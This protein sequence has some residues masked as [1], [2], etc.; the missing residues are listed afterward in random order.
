MS[1]FLPAGATG[2]LRASAHNVVPSQLLARACRHAYEE[3]RSP[4]APTGRN[5]LNTSVSYQSLGL[6]SC[7]GSVTERNK[8][9]VLF[10]RVSHGSIAWAV[11]VA[12]NSCEWARLRERAHE[13]AIHQLD[14]C[15]LAQFLAADR[16][17]AWLSGEPTHATVLFHLCTAKRWASNFVRMQGQSCIRSVES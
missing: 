16:P 4:V 14:F 7:C 1:P 9:R 2:S 6:E 11:R 8:N 13:L 12:R 5:G 17:I 15:A 3:V 10:L